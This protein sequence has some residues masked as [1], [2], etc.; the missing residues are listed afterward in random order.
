MKKYGVEREGKE[1]EK[2][3]KRLGELREDLVKLNRVIEH[4]YYY[5]DTVTVFE[6]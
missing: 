2:K 3:E 4:I 1:I 5:G 6:R